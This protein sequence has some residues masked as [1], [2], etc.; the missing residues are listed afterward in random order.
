[1]H[2]GTVKRVM[3]FIDETDKY[4]GTNLGSAIVERVRKE[5][6]SGATVLRGMVGFGIHGQ[7]HTTAIVDVS[8]NLPVLIIIVDDNDVIDRVL[9]ILQE[10]VSEG[11]I[12]VDEVQAIRKNGRTKETAVKFETIT[13]AHHLVVEYMDTNPITVTSEKRLDDI[14][15]M[16]IENQRA[17]ISVINEN[18][19]LLGMISSQ[20]LL[21]RVVHIPEG[22][23][24]FF[25]LRGAEKHEVGEDIRALTASQVMRT[26][27]AAVE[28]NTPMVKAVQIMLHDKISALP[29]VQDHKLVGILR[30]PDVL[31]KALSVDSKNG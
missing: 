2:T 31:G 1:M 23:F 6:C 13:D 15:A 3:I 17:H 24:R 20:D 16:L 14:V 19:V 30:L 21:G 4:H 5:G 18:A 7:V 25:T 12:L 8:V 28:P 27:F 29:V 11:L 10:M 22:P 26:H 9:P